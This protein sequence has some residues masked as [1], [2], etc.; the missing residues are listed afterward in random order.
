MKNEN[1][2]FDPIKQTINGKEA[3]KDIW[4]TNV[5]NKALEGIQQGQPLKASPFLNKNTKLL[6]P[7]LVRKYTQE[8]IEDYKRCA[9]DPVYFGNSV[10]K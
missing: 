7:E 10:P 5:I 8:E 3:D 9:M 2:E 4:S 6:K 1:F